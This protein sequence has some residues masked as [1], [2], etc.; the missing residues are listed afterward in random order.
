MSDFWSTLHGFNGVKPVERQNG[1]RRSE[2]G[3]L[4]EGDYEFQIADVENKVVGNDEKA[5]LVLGLRVMWPL[6]HA[7]Q[8]LDLNYWLTDEGA[9]SRCF[10]DLVVL[11]M[12]DAAPF[13]AALR[14]ILAEAP[15]APLQGEAQGQHERPRQG[16]QQSLR[17]PVGWRIADGG[18]TAA[19]EWHCLQQSGRCCAMQQRAARESCCRR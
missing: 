5:L 1:P 19:G 7:G 15:G 18:A 11:G 8:I 4:P 2:V 6:A 12:D 17:Q 3:T 16:L 14:S 10:A 9:V 13:A